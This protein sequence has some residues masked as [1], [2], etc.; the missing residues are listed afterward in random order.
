MSAVVSRKVLER[1]DSTTTVLAPSVTPVAASLPALSL[2]VAADRDFASE[3][4]HAQS[5]VAN[6][7]FLSGVELGAIA[8]SAQLSAPLR[9]V[10]HLPAFPV[11]PSSKVSAERLRL[12]AVMMQSLESREPVLFHRAAT[13]QASI[14]VG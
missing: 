7:E 13:T 10:I 9:T 3:V 14:L 11:P 5:I 2:L 1:S 4:Q 12:P 8:T 6:G